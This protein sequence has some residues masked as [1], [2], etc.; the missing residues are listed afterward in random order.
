MAMTEKDILYYAN[1]NKK[2]LE[3]YQQNAEYA[4]GDNPFILG[5]RPK[6]D[7]DNRITIP[8]AKMAV[9]TMAGYAGR[10]GDRTTEIDNINTE[11]SA[12]EDAQRDRFIQ[13]YFRVMDWNEADLETSELFHEALIQGVAF[14]I[15]WT[16]DTIEGAGLDP[17]FT[18]VPGYQI[19]RQYSEDLKPVLLSFIHFRNTVIDGRQTSIADVYYPEYSERWMLGGKWTRQPEF[20]QSYP[21]TRPPLN[22]Y[23][24]NRHE[25]SFFE[26]EKR[27]I[28]A[29]DKLLSRSVNEVDRFNAAL[30]LFPGKITQEFIQTLTET[31]MIENLGDFERWPEY[32]ERDLN[33][34]QAF[35]GDL[36]DR[37]ERLFH[38]SINVP[39]FSDENFVGNSSGVALA[40]KLLGMEFQAAQIDAYFDRGV[41]QRFELIGQALNAGATQFPL[42]DYELI[43]RNRRNLPT[44]EAT[45]V[46]IAMNLMN[47]VSRETL[48]RIL[49]ASIV[50]NVEK[51]LAALEAEEPGGLITVEGEDRIIETSEEVQKQALNGAQIASLVEISE[52]VSSGLLSRESAISIIL[53]SIPSLSP[54]DAAE[55]VP[56]QGTRDEDE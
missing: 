48:L 36:A 10:Q 43:I 39:D 26:A 35:Y 7:P 17:E 27:L 51:E 25:L 5:Q 2:H 23:K 38:K 56:T 47:I 46:Q 11:D 22:V 24:I 15:L 4:G 32:L 44:D 29:Q 28:D 34:V 3:R 31:G 12:S 33:K 52:K 16:G 18:M 30:A 6:E 19:E 14:E 13:E 37:L 8:F 49:P 45:K 55:L 40:Y 20:D 50:E 1:Q 21:F 54:E 53:V 9:E 41:K 42:D